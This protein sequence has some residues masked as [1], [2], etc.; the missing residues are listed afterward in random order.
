MIEG[1]KILEPYRDIFI[2]GVNL[3]EMEV[4]NDAYDDAINNLLLFKVIERTQMT[5]LMSFC[6][7]VL[8][9]YLS[10][11]QTIIFT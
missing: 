7:L 10:T 8:P 3:E 5:T 1:K 2:P 4:I 11:S 9:S 6:L